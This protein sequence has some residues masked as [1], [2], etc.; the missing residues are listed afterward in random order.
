M[1]EQSV[2][3]GVMKATQISKLM[4]GQFITCLS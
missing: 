1:K 3:K 2:M 4:A